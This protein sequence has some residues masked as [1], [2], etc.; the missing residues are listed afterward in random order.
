MEAQDREF[1][2]FYF[3][4]QF[5]PEETAGMFQ[6][7]QNLRTAG[8]AFHGGDIDIRIGKFTVHFHI[9]DEDLVQARIADLADEQL[10]KILAD[11][12]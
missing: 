11:P 7:G 6:P 8:S 2:Q 3:G 10:R 4:G 12:V 1:P 9:G 5:V